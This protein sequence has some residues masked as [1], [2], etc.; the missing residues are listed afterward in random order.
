M[1]LAHSRFIDNKAVAKVEKFDRVVTT[2]WVFEP[3]HSLLTYGATVYQCENSKDHWDKRIHRERAIERFQNNPIRIVLKSDGP[4]PEPCNISVDWF[5]ASHLIFIFGTHNKNEVDVRRIHGNVKIGSDFNN[6]YSLL[7]VHFPDYI[8]DYTTDDYFNHSIGL[9]L[10][11]M[12]IGASFT[13]IMTSFF[14]H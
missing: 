2:A 7:S 4:I 12:L 11:C 3:Q 9:N 6:K 13:V 14:S 8:F 10:L 5:I 1:R